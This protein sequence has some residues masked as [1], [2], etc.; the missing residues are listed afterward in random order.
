MNLSKVLSRRTLSVI[1]LAVFT[2][3]LALIFHFSQQGSN[4]SAGKQVRGSSESL[5]KNTV[6]LHT[7]AL[8]EQKQASRQIGQADSGLPVRLK[9]PSIN[10]DAP[11]EY[12]GLTPNGAMDAPKESANVAWFNQGPLPGES[13][14]AVIA[15]HF[16]WKNGKA[17]VFDDLHKLRKGDKL[18]VEDG[19]GAVTT[20]VVRESRR[21]DPKAD[22]SDVFG[23]SDGK[24]HLNLVTCEGVWDKASK[25]YSQRLV[26]FTD[27]EV[28]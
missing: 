10:V 20:F 17:S 15:G 11:V 8:L 14:S 12:V 22:A 26:V 16:G 18:S 2:L 7:V 9:I 24:T 28:E 5:V 21:Y 25:T 19:K 13:G 4:L 1:T 27:K 3:F 23:S 6:T